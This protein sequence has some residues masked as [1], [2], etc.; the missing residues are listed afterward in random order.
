[1][2]VWADLGGLGRFGLLH[3]M[4]SIAR[5]TNGRAWNEIDGG[6]PFLASVCAKRLE[7]DSFT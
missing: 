2:R 7:A 6:R 1:M 3:A 5:P 4:A